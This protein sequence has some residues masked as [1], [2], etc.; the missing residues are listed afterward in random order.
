MAKEKPQVLLINPC[1]YSGHN[2]EL[3]FEYGQKF[4]PLGLLY[5]GTFLGNNGYRVKII[6]APMDRNFREHLT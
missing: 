3:S 4:M 6:D 5:L 2:E 1:R